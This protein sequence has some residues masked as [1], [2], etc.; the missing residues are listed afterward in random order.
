MTIE[1][2][3]AMLPAKRVVFWIIFAVCA[4]GAFTWVTA[5]AGHPIEFPEQLATIT[6]GLKP[7]I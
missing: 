4:L 5:K 1:R 6:V 3:R 7:R 2:K